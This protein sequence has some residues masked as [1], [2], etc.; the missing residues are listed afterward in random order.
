MSISTDAA[1]CPDGDDADLWIQVD[2]SSE[3][4]VTGVVIQG[5]PW[6]LTWSSYPDE[7]VEQ[8]QVAYSSDGQSWTPVTDA[9]GFPITVKH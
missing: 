6:S 3:I 5:V 8:F 1:W 7:W 4:Q 9:K 2:L